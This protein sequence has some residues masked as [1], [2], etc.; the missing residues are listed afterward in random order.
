MKKTKK[1][2]YD[3]KNINSI[4]CSEETRKKLKH[5]A[6]EWVRWEKQHVKDFHSIDKDR[7]FH[8]GSI[9]IMKTF[10]NLYTKR[11]LKQLE[12]ERKQRRCPRK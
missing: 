2:N 4:D 7:G 9:S 6:R 11:E 1:N 8:A 5:Y 10:F 3:L 12:S